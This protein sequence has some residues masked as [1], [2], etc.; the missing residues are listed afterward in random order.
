MSLMAFCAAHLQ[1]SQAFIGH[2]GSSN[3]GV[4]CA[5]WLLSLAGGA[6]KYPSARQQDMQTFQIEGQAHQTPFPGG[7]GQTAQ[8][9]LAKAQDFLEDADHGFHRTFPQT[10]DGLADVRLKFVSH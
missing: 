6:W 9:E 10:V 3:W 8:G 2:P 1:R 7:G 5:R 4:S